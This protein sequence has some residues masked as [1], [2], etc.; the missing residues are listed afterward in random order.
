MKKH[1]YIAIALGLT[2]SAGMMSCNDDDVY[3]NPSGETIIYNINVANG[4]LSGADI[5]KGDINSDAKTIE[6]TIPAE[7]DIQAI[8][9]SGK[10]SLGAKFEFDTYDFYTSEATT[11]EQDI[12]VI[13]VENM[14][15]Y[16]VVLHLTD[17]VASPV[18]NSISVKTADGSIARGFVSDA[19][20]TVYL[21]CEGSATA[22]VASITMI[23][24]RSTYTFTTANNGV[25]SV[26][27]PGQ[28]VM[29]FGGRTTT[30]DVDFG[31]SPVFGADFAKAEVFSYSGG[32]GNVWKDFTA[33]N[34]RWAQFDGQ[35]LIFASRE[36]GVYPKTISYNSIVNGSPSENVLDV[37]GI[38]GGTFDISAC[39]F[40]HGHIYMT[41]LTT[42]LP[43]PTFKIYH[44]ANTTAP[45]E[46]ILE[47]E[48]IADVFQGRWGDNMS[49]DLDENGNG[50]IWLFDHAGGA[51]VLRF[52]VTG[53]TQINP[54]P[55]RIDCPYTVAYYASINR[56]PNEENRYM[57]TSSNQQAILLVDADLNVLNRI[58]IEDGKEYPVRA[59]NDARVISF[60]GERY[61]VTCNAWGW[62][63]SKAQTIRVYD[64]S[65]GVD[66]QMAITNFNQTDRTPIYQFELVGGNCSAYSANTG[67]AIDEAGNLVIM[68]AA[69]R[70]GF[71]IIRVPKKR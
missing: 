51:F 48:G 49:M 54:E 38:G 1:N 41:N 4:G 10:L 70:G 53:F 20:N 62:M 27:N 71:A 9:F 14:S 12:N 22:E 68:G 59:E 8:R 15:T 28:L 44:W 29:E 58:E 13:N 31:G 63:Y 6:F 7:T 3:D 26:D 33:E 57:M 21:N 56:I 61:L 40:A 66:T 25:I 50:Y 46:T 60:N 30:L 24:R 5:I 42:S 55:V 2:V 64:L 36:G 39:S 23:P 52:D 16:H 37:T 35:N 34:T 43:D 67:A 19:N 11:L 65:Q 45:C 32:T 47:T 17:P 18:L 69:P